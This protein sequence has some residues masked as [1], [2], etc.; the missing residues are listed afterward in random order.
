MTGYPTSKEMLPALLAERACTVPEDVCIVEAE[1]GV[2]VSYGTLHTE[3][4]GL[5]GGLRR[6]GVVAGETVATML[7]HSADTYRFWFAL[8]RLGALEVPIST[9]YRGR[10]LAHLLEDSAATVLVVDAAFVG[11]VSRVLE[12]AVLPQLR[13]LVV[14]GD[15]Q[16]GDV[17]SS[18]SVV[19]IEELREAATL[20]AESDPAPGD[21][22]L[23]LYTSGTTGAAKGVLVPWGQVHATVTGVF[24]EG[25]CT[26]GKVLYGPFPP[27]HIGGRLFV[28]MSIQYGIPAVIRDTFSASAYWHDVE[29]HHCTTTALVSAMATILMSAPPED[30]D[31]EVPLEDVLMNPLTSNYRQLQER[32]GVR[33]CTDFNMTETSIP[34]HSGWDVDDWRSCGRIRAGSPGYEVRLVDDVDQP[35]PVGEVGELVCRTE[36]P[37]SL[38]AGYLGRPD[39]S[40]AA[41]RNGWFH[42]GDLFRVDERGRYY[43]VDRSKDAIRRRGENVS[44]FEVEREVLEHP[45]VL[46]CAAIG[47]PSEL[48]EEDIK[49]FVVCRPGATL[50]EAQ[51]ADHVRSRAASFMVPRYVEFLDAL[52]RTEATHKVMKAH[53][54]DHRPQPQPGERR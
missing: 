6:L 32:F 17:P 19:P 35:V 4:G 38:N 25:T 16:P 40:A 14:R 11:E 5:A 18:V 1:T 43:F 36:V 34:L 8:A 31:R 44:S 7:T 20:L 54:R 2:R 53:L 30:R 33:V 37:W 12:E 10:M 48:G 9:R 46:E 22:A 3:V 49:V 26:P 21:L 27:N 51:L 42:T 52:P 15:R 13:T 50:T 23:V 47:V 41:W 39:D 28:G 24:P 45:D 29:E